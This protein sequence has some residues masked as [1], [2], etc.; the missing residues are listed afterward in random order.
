MTIKIDG[1]DHGGQPV[2]VGTYTL[3]ISRWVEKQVGNQD[4]VIC[5]LEVVDDS[6]E[7]GKEHTEWLVLKGEMP[8]ELPHTRAILEAVGVLAASDK[9]KAIESSDVEGLEFMA[10]FIVDD[11][12]PNNP[13]TKIE[14]GSVMPAGTA[15]PAST[16]TP[17]V[18][19]AAAVTDEKWDI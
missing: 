5:D 19:A 15:T 14:H 8:W 2:G 17:D 9:D 7:R 4:K 6:P 1:S 12:D 18:A 16:I 11:Y 13:R 3:R 10:T